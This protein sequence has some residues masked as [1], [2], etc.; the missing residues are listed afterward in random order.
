MVFICSLIIFS[1]V[2]SWTDNSDNLCSLQSNIQGQMK[3]S[4]KKNTCIVRIERLSKCMFGI[5]KTDRHV[6]ETSY[7]FKVLKRIPAIVMKLWIPYKPSLWLTQTGKKLLLGIVSVPE[8][9]PTLNFFDNPHTSRWLSKEKFQL[10]SK[11]N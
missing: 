4:L 8:I 7:M 5:V 6:L 2:R 1:K 3:R 11:S 10:Q 9:Y